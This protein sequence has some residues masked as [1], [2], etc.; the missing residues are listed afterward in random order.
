[1]ADVNLYNEVLLADSTGN[2]LKYLLGAGSVAMAPEQWEFK[3]SELRSQFTGDTTG[4]IPQGTF[5]INGGTATDATIGGASALDAKFKMNSLGYEFNC[6]VVVIS[7]R[8]TM[9]MLLSMTRV[10]EGGA[11]AQEQKVVD[12]I[13]F[14][15]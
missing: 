14:K 1:M 8:T 15:K 6:R 9:Y 13:E 10:D 7:H 2:D 5:G 4:T 3:K 11:P 12:S